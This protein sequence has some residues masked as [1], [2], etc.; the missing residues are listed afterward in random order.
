MVSVRLACFDAK[1]KSMKK[2]RQIK[3]EP[4]AFNSM[5]AIYIT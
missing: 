2:G 4:N 3:S 1:P 5:F